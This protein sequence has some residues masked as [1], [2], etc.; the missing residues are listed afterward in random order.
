MLLLSGPLAHAQD[1]AV[2]DTLPLERLYEQLLENPENTFVQQR[3]EEERESIHDLVEAEITKAVTGTEEVDALEEGELT[4][5]VERQRSIVTTLEQRL[6]ERT[7]ALEQ[8][9]TEEETFYLD[10]LAGES[11]IAPRQTKSHAELLA[12]MVVLESRV[13]ALRNTLLLQQDRLDKLMSAQRMEQYAVVFAIG[14]YLL[15]LLLIWFVERMIRSILLSRI[16]NEDT[17]YA[18]TKL[19]SSMVY[20]ATFVW[21]AA[22]L[23]A[24]YP[25]LIAS[26][27]IIGA[28]LA[29]ALQDIVKDILGWFFIF[30]KHLYS[31]G[32]RITI[33][34]QTGEVVDVSPIRTLLLEVGTFATNSNDVLERTGKLLNIPNGLLLTTPVLNHHTTS[35]FSRAE[36][37]F[38]ITFESDWREARTIAEE[39]I[40][41]ETGPYV[42]QER[43]QTARRTRG[44]YIPHRTGGNQVHL[45]I[46]DDGVILTLRFTIPVGERRPVLTRITD[47]VL[48]RF[49]ESPNVELAYKT[50]RVIPTPL[51]DEKPNDS[52][53]LP[54]RH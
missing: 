1:T 48:E 49:R 50:S 52:D 27:A 42:A 37:R 5:A 53:I 38:A 47:K 19:F 23:F 7:V 24:A 45:E 35:D 41:E 33:G 20:I 34:E 46:G 39:V 54:G 25:N 31:I 11:A 22:E 10:P 6:K 29:I 16:Q 36:D 44:Y 17:R 51:S 40:E 15:I 32:D 28:G 30:Q 14:N 9:E 3:I 21:L 18:V 4:D 12:K 13:D 43:Q 26:F 2:I 8:L